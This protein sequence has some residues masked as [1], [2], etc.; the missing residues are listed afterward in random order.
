M[1]IYVHVAIAVWVSMHFVGPLWR[2]AENPYHPP[3]ADA[4]EREG[5]GPPCRCDVFLVKHDLAGGGGRVL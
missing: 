4:I 5:L 2:H 3:F 1:L